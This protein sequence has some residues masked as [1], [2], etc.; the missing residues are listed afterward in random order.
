MSYAMRSGGLRVLI[1]GTLTELE[2]GHI[3]KVSRGIVEGHSIERPAIM[4]AQGS[5]KK[6]L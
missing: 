6:K 3:Q 4:T 5:L 1:Y 2:Y